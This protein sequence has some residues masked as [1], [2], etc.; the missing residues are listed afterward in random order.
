MFTRAVNGAPLRAAVFGPMIKR[1]LAG[2]SIDFV[3]A[4]D[5]DKSST[6]YRNGGIIVYLVDEGAQITRSTMKI[7]KLSLKLVKLGAM[8]FATAEDLADGG[9]SGNDLLNKHADAMGDQWLEY[10]LWGT[11]AG[12]P[13]GIFAAAN[14]AV[15]TTSKVA[16][17]LADSLDLSNVLDMQ[18]D[19]WTGADAG[20]IWL[21]NRECRKGLR[22]LKQDI[23]TGGAPV[24]LFERGRAG[25]A[26][27][28]LDGR[29]LWFTD[30]MPALGDLGDMGLADFGQYVWATKRGG[31]IETASS[32][33][34][35]FDYEE[36]AFRSTWRADGR[37]IWDRAET[38]RK[39][40]S[41]A[42][43]SPYVKLEARA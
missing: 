16:G 36:T 13:L 30:H 7:R 10:A 32:I 26:A 43:V 8:S 2:N 12:Q 25:G 31:G 33:H 38:P 15:I 6:T 28:M 41:G 14:P 3:A 39:G 5:H 29:D 21:A 1:Q 27:D 42:T 11:G 35:R 20:A 9:I 17:Q 4:I 19:L 22:L 18:D 23:G 37:P 24:P 40:A 34:L